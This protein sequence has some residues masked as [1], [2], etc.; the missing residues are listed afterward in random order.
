MT[1]FTKK[2]FS[3]AVGSDAYRENYERIFKKKEAPPSHQRRDGT[4]CDY[5]AEDFCN[6]CGW[7]AR[8]DE[9][10]TEPVT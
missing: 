3:V 5:L 1:N 7:I 6:K 8:L 10:S 9:K 2:S 4:T